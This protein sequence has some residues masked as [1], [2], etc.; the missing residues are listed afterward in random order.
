[1]KFNAWDYLVIGITAFTFVY[2]ANKG[3]TL[4]GLGAYKA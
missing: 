3:L 4:A 2:L 1:M